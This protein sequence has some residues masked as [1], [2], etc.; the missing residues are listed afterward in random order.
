MRLPLLFRRENNDAA[1]RERAE[2]VEKALTEG[3]RQLS[4]MFK[5]MADAVEERR[6]ARRGFQQPQSFLERTDRPDRKDR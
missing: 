2:A 3:L 6:L 1:R 5:K 4:V